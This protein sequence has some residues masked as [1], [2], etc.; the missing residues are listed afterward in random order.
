MTF[1]LISIVYVVFSWYETMRYW[2]D[3]DVDEN[4]LFPYVMGSCNVHV[5]KVVSA[6]EYWTPDVS[7]ICAQLW[8]ST[9]EVAATAVAATAAAT[10]VAI[11][12]AARVMAAAFGVLYWGVHGFPGWL[13]ILGGVFHSDGWA[14]LLQN[15]LNE[16]VGN[17]TKFPRTYTKMFNAK[18][19]ELSLWT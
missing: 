15:H 17:L 13:N 1:F 8:R 7:F 4:T 9:T 14:E 16:S 11:I 18:K 12:V 19:L 5:D 2:L 6:S 3:T 10:A